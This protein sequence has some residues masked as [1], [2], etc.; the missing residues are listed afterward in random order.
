M[1][2]W[3]F[4]AAVRCCFLCLATK[5]GRWLTR[6]C[7][8]RLGA[9]GFA[10]ARTAG[11]FRAL[12]VD[13][14]EESALD[15]ASYLPL[16]LARILF[17]PRLRVFAHAN[18]Q[19]DNAKF[20]MGDAKY[21]VLVAPFDW[22]GAGFGPLPLLLGGTFSA[23]WIPTTGLGGPHQTSEL[24]ILVKSKSNRLNFERIDCSRRVL[25]AQRKSM[26]QTV[27]LRAH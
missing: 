25:E 18:L 7:A 2:A 13:G 20:T 16:I 3:L 6:R 1:G 21:E 4:A 10:F 9:K 11:L 22:G 23:V 27:R 15:A 19:P 14:F 24:S 17:D 26:V 5:P 12:D 8:A